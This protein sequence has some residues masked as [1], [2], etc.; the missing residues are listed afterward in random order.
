VAV[1]EP[2]IFRGTLRHRRFA[3]VEH[4]FT[5]PLFMV[6]L[7][8][9]RIPETMARSR[10]SSYNRWNWATFDERDHFG[11]PARPLRERVEEDA[12]MHGIDLRGGRIYLLTHLRYLG[13]VFNPVSFYYCY[14]AGGALRAVL[15]EVNNTF[16]GT[17]NY[18][19]SEAVALHD[20]SPT[21]SVYR[22]RRPKAMYV[23]PF[24]TMDQEYTFTFS[25]PGT[26]LVAHMT[27]VEDEV[28]TFDATLTLN[29]APWSAGALTG[30]L[31]A[32]PW[33]TAKVIGAIHWQALRLYLRGVPVVPRPPHAQ[34]WAGRA[35]GP[36][37]A[38]RAG[39]AGRVR[40]EGRAG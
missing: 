7:D 36:G 17:E 37:G 29:G 12:A 15:A 21:S 8:V 28:T 22:Y 2:A 24:M 30:A 40:G 20:R 31:A 10:F 18:W 23:S 38:G 39:G 3:P 26:R 32:H 11:D 6:L 33:M 19:L 5:Y 9:D 1:I 35:G 34:E 14:D 16:G 27:V 13:Y 4:A 25:E